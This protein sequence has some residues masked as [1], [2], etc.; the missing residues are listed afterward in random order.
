MPVETGE[1]LPWW[2]HV[3]DLDSRLDYPD[4]RGVRETPGLSSEAL[5][6]LSRRALAADVVVA[7]VLTVIA[8][9][10]SVS[11]SVNDSDADRPQVIE[12][13]RLQPAPPP[14]APVPDLPPAP[15]PPTGHPSP[16][17]VLPDVP[18][19][20][21][22]NL[23][24]D[25]PAQPRPYDPP[26]FLVA[27][28][29]LPLAARRRYPLITFW[30]VLAAALATHAGATWI[31]V[32][33][34]AV[35]AYGAVAYS[36]NRLLAMGGLV[37]A[38]VLAGSAF[39]DV[40][41][42][43]PNWMGPFVVLLSVGVFGSFVRFWRRQLGASR[44]RLAELQQA[45]ADAMHRAVAEERSRI[46]AELHDVVTHNVSVMVI[47]AGAARKVMD[48][49]PEQSKQAL[50]AIESGG[51]AAMAEL[52]HV[53][54]LLAG[55]G[56]ER[57]DGPSDGLEP[58]PGLDQ[59]DALVERVRAAGVP[60]SVEV[61]AP[62]PL[63]PGIDLAAYRVV[64]EALTN[65]I[66]HAAGAAASVT[67]GHDGDWLEIEVT[68]TGGTRSAWPRTGDGRGLIGLRERLAVYGGTLDAGRTVGGG[69]RIKARVPWR[70][71]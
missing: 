2:R 13:F 38:A 29:A 30:V 55:P 39:R 11:Y 69:F 46:A 57:L 10:V 27:L 15:D 42:G 67:I 45:Q 33:T 24:G 23:S 31:T 54:G 37:L 52:R 20:P 1:R 3:L 14:P 51:R 56:G 5:P 22:G 26:V 21:P 48:V 61:S 43:L 64:Q 34:C 36:R 8:V 41:P 68:D 19:R 71:T 16:P 70:T 18:S 25:A 63:P 12:Y 53:M 4:R 35:A 66:K 40:A 58:Q 44:H 7:I 28:T 49:E 32:L 47:Q 59:L 60:V 9:T 17:R 65:T 62:G 50:L 6:R